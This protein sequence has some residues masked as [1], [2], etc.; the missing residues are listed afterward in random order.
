M[1]RILSPVYFWSTNFKVWEV[2]AA[3][4]PEFFKVKNLEEFA[5]RRYN[6]SQFDNGNYL[7]KF[8]DNG[9]FIEFN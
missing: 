7:A 2:I 6:L 1:G 9:E 3:S 5:G 8:R 4:K